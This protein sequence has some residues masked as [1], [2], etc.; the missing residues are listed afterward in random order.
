M[1]DEQKSC[2]TQNFTLKKKR[3]FSSSI[4]AHIAHWQPCVGRSGSWYGMGRHAKGGLPD[5]VRQDKNKNEN[6][7][8]FEET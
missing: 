8:L 3:Y 2:L 7:K 4:H 1:N 6:F 5:K